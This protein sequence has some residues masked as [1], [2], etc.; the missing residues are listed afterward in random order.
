M[1]EIALFQPSTHMMYL[2]TSYT[3]VLSLVQP[4]FTGSFVKEY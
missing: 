4:D 2:L 3:L 1:N